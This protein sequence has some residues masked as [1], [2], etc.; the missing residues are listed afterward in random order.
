MSLLTLGAGGAGRTQVTPA[1]FALTDSPAH[2]NPAFGGSNPQVA[3][4]VAF[5][6]VQS[7]YAAVVG[8]AHDT[9]GSRTITAVSIGGISATQAVYTGAVGGA[10]TGYWYVS[11]L[12][13]TT[14]DVSV[15]WN[16]TPNWWAL[17]AYVVQ[18]G[19]ATPSTA[20]GKDSD[21]VADPQTMPSTTTVPSNGVGLIISA[22]G[23]SSG[24]VPTWGGGT[25]GDGS[26]TFGGFQM[27]TAHADSSGNWVPTVSGSSGSGYGFCGNAMA[28]IA[29]EP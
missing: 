7:G 28:T 6:G 27:I 21:S 5:T 18:T 19:T 13:S 9:P 26:P 12:A 16:F 25:T 24:Q 3:S 22:A 1:S 14:A 29:W 15:T 20:V 4:S 8:I 23:C 11:T 2:F 10:R 17:F